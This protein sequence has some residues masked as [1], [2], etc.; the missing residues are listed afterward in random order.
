M[1]GQVEQRFE[2]H[3]LPAEK[4]CR[5]LLCFQRSKRGEKNGMYPVFNRPPFW[6]IT[7]HLSIKDV[8]D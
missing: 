4:R 6:E 2:Q 7:L 8:I 1:W 3:P 5:K